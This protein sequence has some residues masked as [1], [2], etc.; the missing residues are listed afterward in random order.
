MPNNKIKSGAWEESSEKSA[1]DLKLIEDFDGS[2]RNCV[3]WLQ[4]V[5]LVSEIRGIK[6]LALVIPLRLTGGAFAVYQQL[7]AEDKKSTYKIES[8]LK[9]AFAADKFAA[10]DSFVNRKMK[11]NESADVYLADL[12]RLAVLFGGVSDDAM[13]CAFVNGLPENVKQLLRSGARME[14]MSLSE[15]L[16][17]VRAVS[18]DEVSLGAEANMFEKGLTFA[19]AR[20]GYNRAASEESGGQNRDQQ[21]GIRC[22][23]CSGYD[24]I[25]KFCAAKEPNEGTSNLDANR[26]AQGNFAR[27]HG[28]QCF[29]CGKLGH[30]AKFCP[31]NGKEGETSVPVSSS[32]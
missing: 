5:H 15:I 11:V 30:V 2:N 16:G 18:H 25:A 24:H 6:D 17:R 4:K 27:N 1:V 28:Y 14:S 21:S 19:A 32:K 29:N 7:S 23:R 31:G 13:I 12:K 26:G 8:A 9:S 20:T 10:Y 3:E 22:F